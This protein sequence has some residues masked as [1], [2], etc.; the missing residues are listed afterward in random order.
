V[1]RRGRWHVRFRYRDSLGVVHGPCGISPVPLDHQLPLAWVV[2]WRLQSS[3]S[4]AKKGGKDH[5]SR[6]PQEP[7][8]SASAIMSIS[9]DVVPI[10]REESRGRKMRPGSQG[11]SGCPGP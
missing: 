2:D 7:P 11:T 4:A 9:V 3:A 6:L 1:K 5:M 10:W 8:L